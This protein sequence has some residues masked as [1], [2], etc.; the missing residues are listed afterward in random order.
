MQ[1]IDTEGG[2]LIAMERRL[3]PAW[4]GA[5]GFP[6]PGTD[7]SR[8]CDVG[9][10]VGAIPVGQGSALVLGDEPMATAWWPDDRWGEG[11]IVRWMYAPNEPA[12]VQHLGALGSVRFDE[13]VDWPIV[14]GPQ[15]L[16][17]SAFAGD[18]IG[19]RA[20]SLSLRPGVYQVDTHVSKPDD[21]MCLVL[22]RVRLATQ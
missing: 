17:D 4:R 12:V 18:E 3:L 1:W 19:P 14:E 10:Y 9:G 21:E 7:Y 6:A 8:A 16:F 11:L 20:I 22:H 15:L 2:P 5:I 13:S